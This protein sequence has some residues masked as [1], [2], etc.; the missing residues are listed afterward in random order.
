MADSFWHLP[1]PSQR[2][3]VLARNV[4]ATSQPL[5]AS[6]GLNVMRSGGNAVDAAVAVAAV[7]AV[8]EP[9]NNGLGAD[10]F[11]LVWHD[12]KLYGLNA[13]GR[14]PAAMNL[15][16][17]GGKKKVPEFG[18]EP[19]TVPGAVS[20]WV[21]LSKR[22]GRLPFRD[23]LEPAIHY[24]T[25]G[26]PVAPSTA[27]MW[28]GA[29]KRFK[30]YPELG[31]TFL[32]RGRAP[33]AGEKFVN[34]DQARS[35]R[36]IADTQGDAF[37][38][39]EIAQKIASHAK[40]TGGWLTADDLA[41]HS[42]D[43][44]EPI[45]V[46]Y[47]G[48]RLHEIPPNGQGLAALMALG[49]LRERDIR[50]LEP[51]CPDVLHLG[52]EAIKLSFA[53]AHQYIADPRFM[54]VKVDQLLDSEYLSRRA[55][56]IEPDRAGDPRAGA[57]KPGGTI[58][59]TAADAQGTMVALIQSNY[60]GF[61][62]GIVVPGTGIHLQ[63]RG[64]CFTLERGHPNCIAGGKRPYHTIIP[65]FLTRVGAGGREEPVMAFGVMGGFMQPQGHL[66]VVTRVV[67]FKQNPQAALDAPRWQVTEGR[68]V[69]IEPGYEKAV[70][71]DLERRGHKLTLAPR[72]SIKF[73]SGQAIFCLNDCYLGASDPRHDGQAVG[74]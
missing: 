73:G 12:R 2:Q 23:V 51:D 69:L 58:L 70:Y 26:F 34:P 66:Q 48:Y 68:N 35:L 33:V 62:S 4:V 65:A 20:G 16:L 29:V 36:Q 46:D 53:D 64:A 24:A 17:L 31:K 49:I 18:W 5:A 39:G 25:N 43:W 15:K 11:A 38:R 44:V 59:L 7:M 27:E 8:V 56:L 42:A 3:P 30:Q 74:F 41:A 55:A 1:Y 6:A 67:D 22:F 63:D 61:G 13:S 45:S 14:S 9:C 10:N 52:I 47:H 71:D 50:R 60:L 32:P 54:D 40:A 57:P 19:V 72:R 28:A 21:A 37:Y